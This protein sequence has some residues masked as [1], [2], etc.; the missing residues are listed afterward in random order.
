MQRFGLVLLGC[1][2][3]SAAWA[4]SSPADTA[5]AVAKT[6][7]RVAQHQAEVQ[8]LQQDV[9]QQESASQR[10][11]ERLQQQDRAIEALR[12]QL[13]AVHAAPTPSSSGH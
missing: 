13:E 1:A 10:A 11:A 9:S 7:Q 2:L 3:S 12:K 8:R 5:K 6:H 4:Q